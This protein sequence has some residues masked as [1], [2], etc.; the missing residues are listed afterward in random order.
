MNRKEIIIAAMPFVCYG[1]LFQCECVYAKTNEW[2]WSRQHKKKKKRW[3]MDPHSSLSLCLSFVE[4]C[5]LFMWVNAHIDALVHVQFVGTMDW[6]CLI[7]KPSAH[8]LALPLF[9]F[10]INGVKNKQQFALFPSPE[11]NTHTHTYTHL[12]FFCEKRSATK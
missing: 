1:L 4:H 3:A 6:H 11:K 10:D 7:T 9:L 2:K 8:F 5:L 12:L